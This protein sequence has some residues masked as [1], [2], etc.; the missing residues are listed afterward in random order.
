MTRPLL[1]TKL[2]IP[3][4]RPELVS[5]PRLIDRLV[6]G[7]HR[8]LTLI[9]APAGF[10]KTTLLS[11]C[12]V[13]CDRPV[14][15][16][17]LDKG[18]NDPIRFWTYFLAALQTI[19]TLAGAGVGEATLA[20]LGSSGI[21]GTTAPPPIEA[22]LIDLINQLDEV[23]ER[24]IL[25][26]DDLHIITEPQIHQEFTFLLDNL[27]PAAQGMHLVISSRS[28][29]P[30]PLARLRASGQ[31]TELRIGD[32][33]FTIEEATT[34]LNDVMGF[35]LPSE[36]IAALDARTEG[37]IAGLQM[38]AIS[39][40]GRIRVQGVHESPYR[41]ADLASFIEAFTG[42]HRF[43]LDYLV[44]EVLD[45]QSPIV[46]EF[47]LKTS[48]LERMTPSLCDVVTEGDQSYQILTELDRANLFLVPLDDERRWYRY[49]HLFAD[50]LRSRLDRVL[51]GQTLP[52]HQRASAWYEQNSMIADAVGHAL[53]VGDVERVACL[54]E[55]N[56][57]IMMSHGQMATVMGWLDALPETVV[58]ARPW[59]CV[60][61]A[62]ALASSGQWDAVDPLLREVERN[63]AL[64]TA[65]EKAATQHL[66]GQVMG[67]RTYEAAIN[68]DLARTRELARKTLDLVPE[69][70][71]EV[72][73]FCA[74]LLG[75]TLRYTGNLKEAAQV[76]QEAI[77]VSRAAGDNLA[78]VILF[79]SLSSLQ[80]EQGQLRQAAD[81][82]QDALQLVEESVRQGGRRLPIAA[83]IYARL[84][85]LW[86][87]WNDPQAAVHHAWECLRLGE[88]WGHAETVVTSYATLAQALQAA[89]DRAGALEAIEKARRIAAGLSPWY[90]DRV[91]AQQAQIWLAQEKLESASQWLQDSGLGDDNDPSFDLMLGYMTAARILLAQNQLDRALDLLA[92]LLEKSEAS[93]AVGW[94]IEGLV[95]Q[96]RVFQAQDEKARALTAL[97]RA[98]TLAEPEGY[99][100]I[101]VDEGAPMGELLR[102]AVVRGTAVS[103]VGQLLATLG[104]E[105]QDQTQKT[106]SPVASLVEPLSGRETEVLRLLTTSLSTSEI[107]DELVISVST[108]R[109]HIKNIYAKLDVHS[110]MAAIQRAKE[111]RLL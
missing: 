40:R 56:A 79:V 88:P 10:G 89:G 104:Q 103:Y 22:L 44:E 87:E 77:V 35:D 20:M 69:Q 57:L 63:L 61:H 86:R 37:W 73:N 60:A 1:T 75:A 12:V 38:A 3:P 36:A 98:L 2:Y 54:V 16:V 67:L 93:G 39:M 68:F 84:S 94:V 95:L 4:V 83:P 17:S 41:D 23:R 85:C 15:W 62:W 49:H 52:L 102:Q 108:V 6:S 72:R 25:V 58:R 100:R 110:R 27:P 99:V 96:A 5:R 101:F 106:E 34:F 28:D 51:P 18:D 65:G 53:M 11:E 47:L 24:F 55:G 7:L 8:K 81:T 9:S 92:R 30:W 33:R 90:E 13:S 66:A 29:P 71:L 42:S 109:S 76:W 32:L 21:A 91:A 48:I 19:P 31:I 45:Q 46:Q 111:L 107:A 14:A 78:T 59:L 74:N 64:D 80:I 105:E 50:L 70:D 97:E 82:C 43:I 26:L